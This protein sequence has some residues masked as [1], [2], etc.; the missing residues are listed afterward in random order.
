MSSTFSV[1]IDVLLNLSNKSSIK[2]LM[3]VIGLVWNSTKPDI[4]VTEDS[5]EEL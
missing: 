5:E 2:L 1:T 4:Y 3:I